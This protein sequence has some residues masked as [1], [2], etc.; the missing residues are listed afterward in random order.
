MRKA[1]TVIVLFI[2]S[3]WATLIVAGLFS[4]HKDKANNHTGMTV[5]DKAVM[6]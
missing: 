1:A 3:L 5:S 2:F 6:K 4:G